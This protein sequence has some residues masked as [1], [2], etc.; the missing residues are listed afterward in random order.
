M[1][2]VDCACNWLPNHKGYHWKPLQSYGLKLSLKYAPKPTWS[3][4]KKKGK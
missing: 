4:K 2:S 3:I 1:Q